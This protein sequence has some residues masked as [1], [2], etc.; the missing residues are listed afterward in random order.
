VLLLAGYEVLLALFQYSSRRRPTLLRNR[1]PHH[2]GVYIHAVMQSLSP[3][4]PCRLA[5][6][7]LSQH[8]ALAFFFQSKVPTSALR[9]PCIF[10]ERFAPEDLPLSDPSAGRAQAAEGQKPTVRVQ[11]SVI[12]AFVSPSVPLHRS[13]PHCS[14][15]TWLICPF[16]C[17]RGS[18]P[19]AMPIGIRYTAADGSNPNGLHPN[20]DN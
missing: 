8:G 20:I 9:K 10:I 17:F 6:N 12:S 1:A 16:P 14:K 15:W 19:N 3:H 4:V 18:S 2:V 7:K 5:R 11:T 13:F